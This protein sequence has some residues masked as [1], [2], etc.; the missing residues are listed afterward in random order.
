MIQKLKKATSSP[1]FENLFHVGIIKFVNIF[2]KYLIISFLIRKLGEQSY[3]TLTWVDSFIQYFIV[4]INFGFDM[5]IVKKVIENKENKRAVDNI[6][7]TVLTLKFMLFIVSFAILS[8]LIVLFGIEKFGILLYL[9]LLMGIGEVFFPLWYFQGIQKMKYLSLTSVIAK[10]TLILATIM[11]ISSP[12]HLVRYI[13]ILVFSNVLFGGL[14]LYF[15]IKVS[16]VVFT[17]IK[18]SELKSY[19]KQGFLFYLGKTSTL[20]LN[21]GTIFLIGKLFSTSLVTG[22]DLSSKVI[23]VFVFVFE[24]IQQAVFPSIVASQ[25]KNKLKQLLIFIVLLGLCFFLI[26]FAFSKELLFLLG[27]KEM[28]KHTYLLKE[29]S[30]LI[31][32]IGITNILGG[33]GLVAFGALKKY[34]YSF[35][36]S[37]FLYVASVLILMFFNYLTFQNLIYIRIFVDVFMAL[38]II[39]FSFQIDLFEIKV[40]KK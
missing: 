15:L 31:P 25:D 19:F 35:L 39:L 3:G 26:T 6:I 4:F 38:I 7:S 5:F 10:G 20:F 9:M 12:S 28:E 22:F 11:F 33:C 18:Y 36:M 13:W 40:L 16:K 21:F 34:N 17:R 14:G 27:G 24:V 30:I 1:I 2:S 29:L 23:F 37:A 32:V 8:V